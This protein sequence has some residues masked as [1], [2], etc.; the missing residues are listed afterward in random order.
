MKIT[1]KNIKHAKFASRE[2]Y[3]FTANI[4]VDGKRRGTVENDGRGGC[5]NERWDDGAFGKTVYEY[6]KTLPEL[7][8]PWDETKTMPQSFDLMISLLVTDWL[9][10]KELKTEMR[11]GLLIL[12][13]KCKEG[14]YHIFTVPDTYLKHRTTHGREGF[15]DRLKR[16]GAID[17]DARCL[18]LMPV[19]EAT[20]IWAKL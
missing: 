18:N 10:A 2:T 5:N 13:S 19:E 8:L 15:F 1:L 16:K 3:C 7:P 14:E 9:T 20:E 12:D 4:Y 17:E 11:K 6:I